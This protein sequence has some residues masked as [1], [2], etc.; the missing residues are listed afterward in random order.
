[1]PMVTRSNKRSC[2]CVAEEC[3]DDGDTCAICL[4][5]MRPSDGLHTLKCSHRFHNACLS[6]LRPNY[7]LGASEFG[8]RTCPVCRAPV[9]DVVYHN[10]ASSGSPVLPTVDILFYG[11]YLNIGLAFAGSCEAPRMPR[12]I[13]DYKA[14]T[15]IF[16]DY[17]GN[18]FTKTMSLLRMYDTNYTVETNVTDHIVSFKL[19]DPFLGGLRTSIDFPTKMQKLIRGM[20]PQTKRCPGFRLAPSQVGKRAG[21]DPAFKPPTLE[22]T[23][24]IFDASY[25]DCEDGGLTLFAFS[26]DR[27]ANVWTWN[28][29]GF[30]LR[31]SSL[32]FDTHWSCIQ[33]QPAHFT[34]IVTFKPVVIDPAGKAIRVLSVA[35]VQYESTGVLPSESNRVYSFS[36]VYDDQDCYSARVDSVE[37]FE[38]R[39]TRAS[40]KAATLLK[41]SFAED[42]VPIGSAHPVVGGAEWKTL[43]RLCYATHKFCYTFPNDVNVWN[44]VLLSW[45]AN[46]D[47][48]FDLQRGMLL[49]F[50]SV[51]FRKAEQATWLSSR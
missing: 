5:P 47:I 2:P 11:R 35:S 1:M 28:K 20:V 50:T 9:V 14:P 6:E 17:F 7:R 21:E 18:S 36:V 26:M 12:E 4:D 39:K 44:H 30:V 29:D 23:T 32:H 3:A 13:L 33:R 40:K 22:L 10:F 49:S 8:G 37:V 25:Y 43:R 42:G 27:I 15:P 31:F 41:H 34:P 51:I 16:L 24:G 19:L 46:G 45:D 38:D 48:L